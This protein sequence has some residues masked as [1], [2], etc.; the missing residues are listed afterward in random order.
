MI[1]KRLLQLNSWISEEQGLA[2]RGRQGASEAWG[3]AA[4]AA[5]GEYFKNLLEQISAELPVDEAISSFVQQSPPAGLQSPAGTTASW[6]AEIMDD[7]EAS[8][9][10]PRDHDRPVA[11]WLI[12]GALFD[13]L[14]SRG[15]PSADGVPIS[16][17]LAENTTRICA[18][19]ELVAASGT[20]ELDVVIAA[21]RAFIR[22]ECSH[23]ESHLSSGFRSA[24]GSALESALDAWATEADVGAVWDTRVWMGLDM[25]SERLGMLM[26]LAAVKPIDF[27]PLI[28]EVQ[29]FPL[30]ESCFYWRPVTLDLDKVLEMLD[31]APVAI[32]QQNGLW[33]R[34]VVA[35]LL[36]QTAFGVVRELST[37]RQNNGT[38]LAD[39]AELA[40][41][42]QTIIERAL[43]RPDGVQLVSRWMRHQVHAAASSVPDP[44]FEAVFNASLAAFARAKVEAAD[45]YPL[46][47]K[48][49]PKGGVFPAQLANDE[50]NGAYE[51]LVL[52]AMLVQERAPKGADHREASLRPSFIALMRNARNPFS[53]SYGEVMPTW[54]HR[55]FAE[56]YVAEAVAAKS[57]REDFDFF[58]PERRAALHYSYFD[59]DSLMAPSLF[60]A[61]V[62]LSLIDRCLEADERSLLS[63]QGMT[64]WKTVFEATQLLF[65]HW[66]LS[67]DAWR[68]VASSLFARYPGC[69]RALTPSDSLKEQPVQWLS[70]LGRDEGLVANALAN[71]LNNGMDVGVIC[72]SGAAV[73][74]MKCRMRNY[75]EW[76]G[77]AGSRML[78]RGVRNYLV[79]NFVGRTA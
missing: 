74:E 12:A 24:L 27:L 21:M 33:N 61:G 42:A 60:L 19:A 66:S 43:K 26:P 9:L 30:Q 41:I 71:L 14:V 75:L 65:T 1:D 79:K 39:G 56:I 62:G 46:M 50:A 68:N 67:N 44:A 6:P 57:W 77:G 3:A 78:N 69:L 73:E 37:H 15:K 18:F 47:T 28:E 36:L 58:A 53:V 34:K 63:H 38:P 10:S 35:P 76:E 70:L 2:D 45:V 40:G 29:P 59:D 5:L 49:Y 7:I 72:G 25:L 16:R 55:V 51:Q 8:L 13:A 64:V 32:D 4:R 48:D 22:D 17:L 31:R 52:A 11:D 54:R 23:P 20:G